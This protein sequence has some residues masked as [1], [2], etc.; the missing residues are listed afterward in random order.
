MAKIP[1]GTFDSNEVEPTTGIGAD[2]EFIGW[3]TMH[4][5]ES[6]SKIAKSGR[7]EYLQFT[8]EVIEGRFKGRKLWARF[9]LVNENETAQRIA[10]ANF[11]AFCRACKVPVVEDSVQLHNRPFL[12]LVD[13]IPAE[14][15][16]KAKNELVEGNYKPVDG[17]QAP[18]PT[19]SPAGGG[20]VPVWAQKKAG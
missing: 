14:S 7:G 5:I 13:Y 4:A 11:S 17:G 16:Y 20:A 6:E 2:P 1:Y 8:L 15:G 18:A 3:H 9:N 12:G 10:A 19:P